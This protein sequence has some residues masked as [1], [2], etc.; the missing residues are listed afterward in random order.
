MTAILLLW[1]GCVGSLV[2]G[3][4]GAFFVS[5]FMA[6]VFG[7]GKELSW[8]WGILKTTRALLFFMVDFA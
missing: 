2:V 7:G 4:L 3:S 6:R 5:R 1:L 8:S